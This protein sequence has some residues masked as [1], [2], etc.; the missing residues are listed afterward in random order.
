[1]LFSDECKKI[2]LTNKSDLDEIV[3]HLKSFKFSP[4]NR[5]KEH[6]YFSAY[7]FLIAAFRISKLNLP[8]E[9]LADESPDFVLNQELGLEHTRAMIEKYEVD[10][11]EIKKRPEKYPDYALLELPEYSVNN[12]LPKRSDIAI[13]KPGQK[14]I[15]EGW[16]NYGPEKEWAE[17]VLNSVKK[18]TEDINNKPHFKKF[19]RNELFVEYRGPIYFPRLDKAIEIINAR[20]LSVNFNMLLKYDKVHVLSDG[21]LIYDI[22]LA[23]RLK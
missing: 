1:M 19:A 15:S 12:K 20:F 7:T 8:V 22:F 3:K 23:R 16:G 6:E 10:R 13:R 9:I 11:S 4:E 5:K 2:V 14:L 17:T 21:Y 18:K